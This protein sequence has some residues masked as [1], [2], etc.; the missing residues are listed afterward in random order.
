MTTLPQLQDALLAELPADPLQTHGERQMSTWKEKATAVSDAPAAPTWE[1]DVPMCSEDCPHHD[2]K[3]CRL[4]GLAPGSICEPVVAEMG[5]A[6]TEAMASLA[7]LPHHCGNGVCKTRAFADY[8]LCG[9]GCDG[10]IDAED[11][12]VYVHGKAST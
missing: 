11:H 2:G 6:L 3:R 9:C 4:L 12:D 10:C 5:R 7:K 1:G 8:N